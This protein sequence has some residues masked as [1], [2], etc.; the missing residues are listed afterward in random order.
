MAIHC[1]VFPIFGIGGDVLHHP[2]KYVHVYT[3]YDDNIDNAFVQNMDEHRNIIYLW[4]IHDNNT[5]CCISNMAPK[6]SYAALIFENRLFVC[7]VFIFIQIYIYFYLLF[8]VYIIIYVE[9]YIW[10]R[11]QNYRDLLLSEQHERHRNHC[12][13]ISSGLLEIYI[14]ILLCLSQFRSTIVDISIHSN[15]FSSEQSMQLYIK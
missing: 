8:N 11:R 6:N 15:F 1:F 2:D 13:Q 3:I 14:I 10:R 4:Q 7:F 12:Y 5:Q 9:V